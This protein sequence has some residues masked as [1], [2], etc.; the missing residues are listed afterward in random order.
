MKIIQGWLFLIG[1]H[2]GF[3]VQRGL[4][5][6]KLNLIDIKILQLIPNRLRGNAG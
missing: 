2:E 4:M 6:R 5:I 1:V 3:A